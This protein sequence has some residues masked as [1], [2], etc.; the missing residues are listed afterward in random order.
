[1]ESNKE[2]GTDAGSV[3]A[4][5]HLNHASII[6]FE[7]PVNDSTI[8]RE[9]LTITA[10]VKEPGSS[11]STPE[12][13]YLDHLF[14]ENVGPIQFLDMRARF[15]SAGR[16][17]PLVFV[18]ENGSGKSTLLSNIVDS[19]FEIGGIAFSNARLHEDGLN[20]RYYK[21]IS[22]SQITIGRDYLCACLGYTNSR[23]YTFKSGD[24]PS[25]ILEEHFPEAEGIIPRGDSN[26]KK[27]TFEKSDSEGFF[28]GRAVCYFD[29]N[30]Y[31]QPS[32]MES[33]YFPVDRSVD[34]SPF[35]RVEGRLDNPIY[36]GNCSDR[37]FAWLLDVIADS[38]CD[39]S[40]TLEDDGGHI[41]IA[42]RAGKQLLEVPLLLR[43]RQNVE[44]V[45]SQILGREVYFSLNYRNQGVARFCI[46]SAE[47][48]RVIAHSLDELSTGQLA[49]FELFATIIRY[50][51][52]GDINKSVT[53]SDIEGIVVI[54]EVDVH[55]H[56]DL[57]RNVLPKLIRLFPKVQF[58]MTT[59][60]PMFL[61]GMREEF[62]TAGFD[63]VELPTGTYIDVENYSEFG[64]A[65]EY[66]SETERHRQEIESY[67]RGGASPAPLVITEG[68]TDWRHIEA[69]R[70]FLATIPKYGELFEEPFDLLKFGPKDDKR[71][72]LKTEMGGRTLERLCEN[73]SKIP[74]G[75]SI[76]FIADADDAKTVK[77]LTDENG[78]PKSWGNGVYS[79]VLPAPDFRSEDPSICI[80]QLYRNDFIR[81][82]IECEDGFSRRLF[83]K[84]EFG[85]TGSH[86]KGYFCGNVNVL[87][88]KG[89]QILDGNSV[90]IGKIGDDRNHALSKVAFANA[91]LDGTIEISSDTFNG[92]IPLFEELRSIIE[93]IRAQ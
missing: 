55:L 37:T 9:G 20:Q 18:G 86:P 27:C 84:E 76:I 11:S 32:W 2:H 93:K 67:I 53:L 29:P 59:H 77:K 51:D 44:R 75:R 39:I 73:I 3:P 57:Q 5:Y 70:K 79:M 69:A 72:E 74:T 14:Y 7:T 1:M 62:G 26:F 12:S 66:F 46:M 52:A 58:I 35:E 16:P 10:N 6:T 71:C 81:T 4:E 13:I 48:D 54:D 25:A 64:R 36:V 91:V 92:F 61:L 24:V 17:L 68:T 21:V 47:N 8:H 42:H 78:K 60:S 43:S 87:N 22:P 89:S 63:I 30:R 85:K 19:F 31:E 45:M 23:S 28:T 50:A 40:F 15:D 38:R 80:E 82:P 49:L 56:S 83:L 41:Q 65:Y 88:G 90:T 33:S 34:Y